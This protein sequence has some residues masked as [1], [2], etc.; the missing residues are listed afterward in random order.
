LRV[1]VTGGCGFI[2]SAV[3]RSLVRDHGVAVHNLDRMTYAATAESVADLAGHPGYAFTRGDVCDRRL[4]D[5]LFRAFRPTA[6]MHLAAESHVDRSILDSAAFIQTNVTGTFTL[7]EAARAYW[8]T[9]DPTTRAA[10][11]FLHV[12]TDEVFGSLGPTGCFAETSAHDPSSPYSASKAG[13]DHLVT[14]W[15]RTYGLPT[16]TAYSSNNFGAYQFPE[17]LIPLMIVSALDGR[18]LPVY[19]DGQNVRDWLYVEDHVAALWAILQRGRPGRAYA[20]GAR[21]EQRNIVLVERICAI[22]DDL[23][24][25]GTPH[26]ELIT[27]VADRPGHDHRYAIDPSRLETELGWRPR[28][29]FDE[30]LHETVRWYL[31]NATWW[32]RLQARARLGAAD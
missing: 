30:A 1:L 5:A 18:P 21:N 28:F 32:R 31:A 7:L 9:A 13:A 2:G 16:L 26:R 22:L 12:S 29:G 8:C 15:H 11:R 6:V 19:G 14:A 17:K 4:L 3:C 24:P 20:V 27:H 25:S 23:R 10:F